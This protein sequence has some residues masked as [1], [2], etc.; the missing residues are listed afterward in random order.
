[1]ISVAYAAA[2]ITSAITA[3]VSGRN[4][5]PSAG[6]PKYT[7]NTCTSSGVLRISSM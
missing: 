3:A 2:L 5:T 6:N 7:K 4:R 1:M